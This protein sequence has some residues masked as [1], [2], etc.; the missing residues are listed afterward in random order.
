M[1]SGVTRN[2]NAATPFFSRRLQLVT[3]KGG[4]GKTTVVAAMAV[5]CARLGRRPLIV[6]MG[7]RASLEGVFDTAR[8]SYVPSV[9][10]PGVHAMNLDMDGAL[11][12]YVAAHVLFRGVAR[13]LLAS[14]PVRA[15]SNAAPAVME[16]A[17]LDKLRALL[18]E[19]ERHVGA[20]V[21]ASASAPKALRWDPV[22]VDLDATGH[23][24]MFLDLPRALEGLAATGPLATLLKRVTALLEDA[25]TTALHLVTLPNA[26]PLHETVELYDRL[27]TSHRVPLGAIFVN[28]VP[29]STLE[30]DL[31]DT[32]GAATTRSFETLAREAAA[33]GLEDVAG[34]L[35]LAAASAHAHD[36]AHARIQALRAQ[37]G[38]PVVELPRLPLV[39]G[40]TLSSLATLGRALA[41]GLAR[42]DA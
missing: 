40:H 22:I 30:G 17:T 21:N 32:A 29:S 23:A 33:L 4:V 27:R 24:L 39:Q 26:L 18:A 5:E 3:G 8:V 28:R 15:F 42:G 10:A 25:R 11:L 36:A 1:T 12:D 38:L 16:M 6:E 34:D 2:E 7:H 9:V 13:Q 31:D 41:E 20:G 37:V 14:A 35:A 19:R